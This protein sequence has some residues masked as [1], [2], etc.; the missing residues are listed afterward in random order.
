MTEFMDI[1]VKGK[2]TAVPAIGVCGVTVL[3]LG[4]RLRIGEIFD[5]YWLER[6]ELP[7]AGDVIAQLRPRPDRPDLFTFA[8]RIPDTEP[9]YD[10]RFETDNYAVLPLRTHEHW[11]N[12]Q[13]P[14]ATRRAIRA[15]AKRGIRVRVA[16]YDDNYVRGIM[17]IYNETR[18]RAGRAFW[19]YGKEFDTVKRENGTYA[20][21]S[22]FLGAYVG[23]EMVGYLKVVWD[24]ETAAIMQILSKVAYRDLRPNNALLS[25]AVKLCATR[26]TRYLLYEKYAYGNKKD[27]SLTKFK[28]NNGFVRMDVPRYFV[29]LTVKGQVGLRLGL[30]KRAADRLPEWMLVPMRNLRTRWNER[31]MGKR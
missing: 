14:A 28:Q 29:P 9:A 18:I 23:D 15:A 10:Y 7:P 13:I 6:R 8:Q 25:E 12:E 11:F 20:G 5:E 2:R 17:S 27:D 31:S 4:R 21:R 3:C 30:H 16:E 1:S 24:E 22:T 26:G 19:H